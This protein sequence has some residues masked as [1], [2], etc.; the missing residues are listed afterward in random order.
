ME[1]LRK[2]KEM[3][4]V[5]KNEKIF[6]LQGIIEQI[7]KENA[8]YEM[9]LRKVRD[10][11]A[12]MERALGTNKQELEEIKCKLN[13]AEKNQLSQKQIESAFGEI[14]ESKQKLAYENGLLQSKVNQMG[15]DLKDY[16]IIKTDYDRL[17][18]KHQ[19]L[20]QQY[21]SVSE[22]LERIKSDYARKN[23]EFQKCKA[24]IEERENEM[25]MVAKSR[26][27]TLKEMKRLSE[28]NESR[29]GKLIAKVRTFV[30]V[31]IFCLLMSSVYM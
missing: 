24:M 22:D 29:E 11:T 26:E 3:M 30:L 31:Y 19:D 27:E 23:S 14:V 28:H 4:V 25:K 21:E 13:S 5:Q 9:T 8:D 16:D 17:K 18:R 6:E 20:C 15:I 1:T 2:D 10:E 12:R 7:K